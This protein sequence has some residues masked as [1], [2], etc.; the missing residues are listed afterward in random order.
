ME[1]HQNHDA[2]YFINAG[3]E[4]FFIEDYQG[5][6]TCYTIAIELDEGKDAAAYISRGIASMKV[7][8]KR[9]AL[10]DFR[11]AMK[12]GIPIQQELLDACK[13]KR[14]ELRYQV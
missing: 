12:L 4:K 10:A 1:Y 3:L 5:A 2:E 7:G 11:K 14:L 8:L 13:E 9:D 6:I